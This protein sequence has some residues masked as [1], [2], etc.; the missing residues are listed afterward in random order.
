MAL[1]SF[2]AIAVL[3][4]CL[5]DSREIIEKASKVSKVTWDPEI[6][7]PLVKTKMS[8]SDM[9]E[10]STLSFVK[11]DPD[12]LVVIAYRGQV[13]SQSAEEFVELDNQTFTESLTLSPSQQI[14]FESNGSIQLQFSDFMT[15]DVGGIEID[16]MIMKVCS[17]QMRFVS[18]FQHDVEMTFNFPD[19][20]KN[21]VPFSFKLD[22]A[23]TGGAVDK[24]TNINLSGYNFDMT[25]GPMGYNQIRVNV[26]LKLTKKGSNPVL[27][28]NKIDVSVLMYYNEYKLLYGYVGQENFLVSSDSLSLDL[29][30][31]VTGGNYTLEDPRLKLI[32]HNSLGVPIR[33]RIPVLQ[34][35]SVKNGAINITGVPN[36]LPL[37][38]PN[39]SQVGQVLTDSV[40]LN[41]GNSNIA[42]AI[43]NK[44]E[45]IVYGFD[46]TAN[47]AGKTVRNFVMDTSRVTFEV[48]V[49]IPLHGSASN[50]VLEQEQPIEFDLEEDI[51]MLERVLVRLA[52]ENGFP[53]EVKMNIYL[54]DSGKTV[55]DSLFSGVTSILPSPNVNFATGKVTAPS[56]NIIDITINKSRLE[57]LRKTKSVLIKAALNTSRNSGNIAPVKIYTEYEL[58]VRIGVQAKIKLDDKL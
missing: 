23:Y 28:G 20:T 55:L 9:V 52:V 34:S 16:S 42:T 13:F 56:K 8:I 29:L 47:P 15:F 45:K 3:P 5:K 32:M 4:G 30:G 36:P 22:G 39:Y 37:P 51:D 57:N 24:S 48:D 26:D 41:K 44:P 11:T 50:M 10:Q 14:Y 21:G 38:I 19:V 54:L 46:V 43:N 35:Y 49:E 33:A 17:N 53:L 6:A 12:G 40:V 18:N 7:I 25:K 2:A 1:L 58:G 31:K 27:P